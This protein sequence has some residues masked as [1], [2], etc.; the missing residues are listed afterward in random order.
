MLVLTIV[1]IIIIIAIIIIIPIVKFYLITIFI[2]I[3]V[4]I[5]VGG[6]VSWLNLSIAETGIFRA[7]PTN[8]TVIDV[9]PI[10]S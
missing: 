6:F 3:I 1:T 10:A 8:T 4:V 9:L 2:I 7:N 5:I